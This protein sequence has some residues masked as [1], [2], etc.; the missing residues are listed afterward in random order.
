MNR[1]PRKEKDNLAVPESEDLLGYILF[2]CCV[3]GW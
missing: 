3:L 1:R 2:F